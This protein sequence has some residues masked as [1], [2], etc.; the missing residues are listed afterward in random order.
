MQPAIVLLAL[1]SPVLAAPAPGDVWE[2]V[3]IEELLAIAASVEGASLVHMDSAES[4]RRLGVTLV[5]APDNKIKDD[6]SCCVSCKCNHA[7]TGCFSKCDGKFG[8]HSDGDARKINC[9]IANGGRAG[10]P[11]TNGQKDSTVAGSDLLWNKVNKI[12]TEPS[13]LGRLNGR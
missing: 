2:Q 8:C 7:D 12:A 10:V 11:G 9:V 1:L 4:R 13:L 3:P 6:K 5:S